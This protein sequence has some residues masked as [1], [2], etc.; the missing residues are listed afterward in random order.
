MDGG[1]MYRQRMNSYYPDVIRSIQEFK[2]IVDS[3]S[4][5]FEDLSINRESVLNDAYLTTMGEARI[6][7]WEKILGIQP[8]DHSTI[9]DRRDNVIARIRGQGKLNTNLIN[10]IVKT[11]TEGAAESWV[12]NGVLYVAITPPPNNKQ[13]RF[14]NVELE[15]S[16]KVPAHLGFQIS[17]NYYTWGEI[18]NSHS[19]WND[20]NTYFDKWNDVLLFVPFK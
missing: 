14:D 15:I 16:K 9:T 10:T 2:A 1:L 4:T 19:T 7:E 11:F 20:V 5:E 6:T 17:R 8:L 18:K 3:E 13:Y 12:E